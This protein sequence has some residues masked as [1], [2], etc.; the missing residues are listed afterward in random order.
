ML[1]TE[2]GQIDICDG[3][4]KDEKIILIGKVKRFDPERTTSL[5]KH[6][7]HKPCYC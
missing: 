7:F 4:S 1:E 3:W 5:C 2:S 6:C